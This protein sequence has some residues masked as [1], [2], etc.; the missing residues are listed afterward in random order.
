MNNTVK[1]YGSIK[2][3]WISDDKRVAQSEVSYKEFRLDGSL[4]QIGTEDFSTERLHGLKHAMVWTWDGKR[5]NKGGHRWF[6]MQEF[7]WF[8]KDSR[9]EL[10]AYLDSKY[11]DA[12]L[13][14][15]R[16]I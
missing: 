11:P 8:D 2:K 12:E 1:I 14:Q 5:Y 10:K 16:T 3:V 7:V 15:I 9:K 13:I 6:E 4:K